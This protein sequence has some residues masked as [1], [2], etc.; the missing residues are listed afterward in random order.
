MKNIILSRHDGLGSRIN[1][2]IIG[3]YI[4]KKI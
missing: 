4:S 3:I 1:N 2:I